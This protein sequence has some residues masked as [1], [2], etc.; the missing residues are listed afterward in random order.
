MNRALGA[1]TLAA[2]VALALT[3]V[4]RRGRWL[5]EWLATAVRYGLATPSW[6]CQAP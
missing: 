3:A 2:L 1:L 4:R 6:A 5:Y